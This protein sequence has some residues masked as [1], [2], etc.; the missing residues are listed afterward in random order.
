[1]KQPTYTGFSPRNQTLITRVSPGIDQT[2]LV[3]NDKP[4]LRLCRS[5]V[6]LDVPGRTFDTNRCNGVY[7]R[8]SKQLDVI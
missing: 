4:G 7:A 5:R 6:S 1:M 8:H 2:G 3:R